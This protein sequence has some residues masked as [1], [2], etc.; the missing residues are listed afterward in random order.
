MN[1]NKF[2]KII[3]LVLIT[4][5]LGELKITPFNSTF[6]FGL[7]SAGFF[8]LLLFYKDVP[9]V[10]AGFITGIFTTLFRTVLDAFHFET[11]SFIDS[12]LTHSPIIGYYFIFAFVFQFFTKRKNASLSPIMLVTIGACCDA[13]ANIAELLL[14]LTVNNTSITAVNIGYILLVAV[15]RS[16]FVVG[17]FNMIESYKLKAIYEEQQLRFEQIITILS[18]LYIE[19]FYLKKTLSV[20]ESTT[21]KAF[22]LYEELKITQ[23]SIET[24][25]IALSIAQEIHEL[26]KD[27]QRILAGLE[28]V[29]QQ[30]KIINPLSLKEI[31]HLSIKANEKYI[32]FLKKNIK[33]TANIEYDLKTHLRY[34]LLVILNNLVANA[35]EAIEMEGFIKINIKKNQSEIIIEIID[36]GPGIYPSEHDVIFEPGFS[37]KF[38][39]SGKLS[40]GIGLS[41]V[42]LMVEELLGSIYLDTTKELTTF[43]VTLPIKLLV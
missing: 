17:L 33:I 19:G 36:N 24:S 41:H 22:D 14:H 43:T 20:I 13:V 39:E 7:G 35:I 25:R 5:F 28:E 9:Y 6:R 15:I 31:I 16:F 27:N 1:T 2:L 10:L 23:A 29:I 8:F 32:E 30:E 26:K 12:F 4:A 40:N 42:K 18:E 21:V 37:T 38:T 11:F 3:I 34:P